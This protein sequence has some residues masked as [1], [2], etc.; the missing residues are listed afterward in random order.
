MVSEVP[1]GNA[2]IFAEIVDMESDMRWK[3]ECCQHGGNMK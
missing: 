3:V 2:E 1:E